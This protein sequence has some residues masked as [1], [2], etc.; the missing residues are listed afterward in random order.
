L[1]RS[2]KGRNRKKQQELLKECGL[3]FVFTI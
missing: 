1:F 3:V 2:R